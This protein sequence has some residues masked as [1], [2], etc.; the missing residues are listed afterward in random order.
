MERGPVFL[1]TDLMRKVGMAVP[2]SEHR[3]SSKCLLP[4]CDKQTAHRGGYCCVEHYKEHK[5]RH[6]RS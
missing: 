4:G 2:K 5:Q 3:I 6:R 1:S